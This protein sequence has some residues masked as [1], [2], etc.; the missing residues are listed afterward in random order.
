MLRRR[1]APE[2]FAAAADRS[3]SCGGFAALL[4]I[5]A[6]LVG[7][8]GAVD[9]R[10]A[11]AVLGFAVL[12]AVAAIASAFG[13]AVVIWRTGR[14]GAARALVGLGLAILVLAYPASLAILATRLPFISDV[15][16][17][18]GDPPAFS[19]LPAALAARGGAVHEAPTAEAREAGRRA[20]P[21]LQPLTFDLSGDEAYDLVDGVVTA[22]GWRIV[23]RAS[24]KGRFGTGH[25]DAVATTPVM[26]M[27]EDV[28][29]RIRPGSGQ[30][31]ID[32]RS[33]SR[34]GPTDF[35]ANAARIQALSDALLDAAP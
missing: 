4:G 16:T 7:R 13:S 5:I 20:Y 25:V 28:V 35:G 11:L 33:A 17:D 32:I 23:D 27:P 10:A 26:A 31:R 9:P 24:P 3:R 8:S 29:I 1:L 2:P 34:F 22:R 15:S 12:F 21:G 14:R 18:P 30:T 19:S 6:V